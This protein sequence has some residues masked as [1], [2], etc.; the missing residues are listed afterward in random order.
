MSNQLPSGSILPAGLLQVGRDSIDAFKRAY[1][2]FDLKMGIVIA[3]YKTTDQKNKN[4]RG[5]EYDVAVAE[6]NE[7]LGQTISTYHNCTASDI[8]GGIAD[9][10]R[11]RYRAPEG[12]STGQEDIKN[13]D[14]QKGSLVLLLNLSGSDDSPI[15]IGGLSHMLSENVAELDEEYFYQSEINGLGQSVKEDGSYKL[16]FKGATDI[17]GKEKDKEVAGTYLSID[18]SGSIELSDGNKEKITIDKKQKTMSL[19]AEG[20]VSISSTEKNIN[21][22]SK[23]NLDIKAKSII[24]KSEGGVTMTGASYDIKADKAF[25]LESSS[26]SL[27]SSGTVNIKGQQV[28]VDGIVFLGGQGGSPALTPSTIYIGSDSHG[29]PVVSSAIGPYSSKVF[30]G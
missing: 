30:I 24:M 13:I 18:K 16:S 4:K 25:S 19:T 22:T 7:D 9:F 1:Q 20:D 5:I 23:A 15:I 26:F 28:V 10:A 14:V 8:F 29:A 3:A 11:F 6:Q 12:P 17:D 21:I 2:N 27:N